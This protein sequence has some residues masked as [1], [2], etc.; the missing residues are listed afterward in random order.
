MT[1]KFY[2]SELVLRLRFSYWRAPQWI[3]GTQ[4][5]AYLA[6]GM[7]TPIAVVDSDSP[8]SRP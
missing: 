2:A 1:G 5:A 6:A 4:P 7:K 3:N 8:L